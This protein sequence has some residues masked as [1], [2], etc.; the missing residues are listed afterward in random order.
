MGGAEGEGVNDFDYRDIITNWHNGNR[1]DAAATLEAGGAV[2][3]AVTFTQGQ[4]DGLLSTED[5]LR[6]T[7]FLLSRQLHRNRFD[8]GAAS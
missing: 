2:V 4:E 8:A 3:T 7:N 5:V 1:R 6:I